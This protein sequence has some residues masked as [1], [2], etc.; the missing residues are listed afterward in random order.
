MAIELTTLTGDVGT[1]TGA[2]PKNCRVRLTLSEGAADEVTGE[3]I[4]P[5]SVEVQA[6]TDG[7]FSIEAWPNDRAPT[8]RPTYLFEVLV[9]AD[10][11]YARQNL[12]LPTSPDPCTLRHMVDISEHIVG[13]KN[14]AFTQTLPAIT[15][16]T[17]PGDTVGTLY[18]DGDYYI[19]WD[20]VEGRR[21]FELGSDRESIILKSVPPYGTYTVRVR[22]RNFGGA[23]EQVFVFTLGA[24]PEAFTAPDWT[25]AAAPDLLGDKVTV[26]LVAIPSGN[27]EAITGVEYRVDGGAWTDLG[28]TTPG[29][30]TLT[31]AAATSQDVELRAVNAIGA[32]AASD[33]KTVLTAYAQPAPFTA[34]MWSV[35]DAGALAGDE[36][37]VTIATLPDEG[38]SAITALQVQIN[39][40][41]WAALGGTATG[42]YTVTVPAF[43]ALTVKVRAVNAA[44]NGPDSDEK[45]AD[46][47][48]VPAAFSDGQFSVASTVPETVAITITGLPADNGSALTDIE[49][50]ID[51]GGWTSLGAAATGTYQIAALAGAEVDI[52]IRAVNEVGPGVASSAKP[53]TPLS[54]YTVSVASY[55]TDRRMRVFGTGRPRGADVA[56]VWVP[57]VTALVAPDDSVIEATLVRA[58]DDTEVQAFQ[59]IGTMSGGTLA[60]GATFTVASARAIGEPCKLKVR[61]ASSATPTILADEVDLGSVVYNPAQS[62]MRQLMTGSAGDDKFPAALPADADQVRWIWFGDQTPASNLQIGEL[63]T[64]GTLSGYGGVNQLARVP[65]AAGM[66]EPLALWI[67]WLGGTGQG[68][69]MTDADTNR[70]WSDELAMWTA[71]GLAE[72][73]YPDV[74]VMPWWQNLKDDVEKEYLHALF[75]GKFLDGTT[76]PTGHSWTVRAAGGLSTQTITADHFLFDESGLN[77]GVFDPAKTSLLFVAFRQDA[78]QDV[79]I[80][81]GD[82]IWDQNAATAAA[83]ALKMDRLKGDLERIFGT[84]AMGDIDAAYEVAPWPVN[85]NNGAGTYGIHQLADITGD[86]AMAEWAGLWVSQGLG[87]VSKSAA[88]GLTATF[89]AGNATATISCAD[90]AL[91]T[92]RLARGGANQVSGFDFLGVPITPANAVITGGNVVLTL[93]AATFDLPN[94]PASTL[95]VGWSNGYASL[96]NDTDCAELRYLDAPGVLPAT[97]GLPADL[98]S[99][100]SEGVLVV[101]PS[102]KQRRVGS[103]GYNAAPRADITGTYYRGPA[104]SAVPGL[105]GAAV[106]NW[107]A[108]M[109]FFFDI[110][111]S[112]NGIHILG[113]EGRAALVLNRQLTL[114]ME[115]SPSGGSTDMEIGQLVPGAGNHVRMDV[116]HAGPSSTFT[117]NVNGRA[118]VA[119]TVPGG[120]SQ[121][122]MTGAREFCAMG[123]PTSGGYRIP[124]KITRLRLW[125]TTGGAAVD[126]GN[127][128]NLDIDASQSTEAEIQALMTGIA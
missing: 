118:Q 36:V 45:A 55:T 113:F 75:T 114:A 112:S 63:K 77:R 9:G 122:S 124:A 116:V 31:L 83:D 11:V 37:T 127:T 48:L 66:T 54:G 123:D 91:T 46:T 78:Q 86:G 8:D 1:L 96:T 61:V 98:G 28:R 85:M 19:D 50:R 41:A 70:N 13:P 100:G 4:P 88:Q 107:V 53:V 26:T 109:E 30:V 73:F 111:E 106:T 97:L 72:G 23:A 51:A 15:G 69:M 82:S 38:I 57:E 24:A 95:A 79:A 5:G 27:G 43:A 62:E 84:A 76:C 92:S 10:V 16:A 18:A 56:T 40:G 125:A 17:A 33:T 105:G 90:G 120:Y 7:T 22:G 119:H 2:D 110:W 89:G 35:A 58:S 34:G 21:Y 25:L 6:E 39:G 71:A 93:P 42:A 101:P 80:D 117:A 12:I 47:R 52:T 102:A 74:I 14:L 44:G 103:A 29:A 32:G 20:L 121:T 65:I 3:I 81:A 64:G 87:L 104:A 99:L 67:P 68:P 126:T 59:T 49:A 115:L 128:P 108:E 94:I 60:A